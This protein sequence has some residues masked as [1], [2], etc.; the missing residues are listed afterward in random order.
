MK[1]TQANTGALIAAFLLLS[2]VLAG[3]ANTSSIQPASSGVS[4]FKGAAYRGES[5]TIS[6]S[7]PGT[8]EFRVFH[9]GATGFVSVQN[10]R[11]DAEQRAT[12]FC[13]R[14][15]KAMKSLRETTSQ[16][17]H[18]LGNFPRIEIIFSCIEKAASVAARTGDD[19]KYTRL[20]N[21][22][23]LLDTGVLS[24]QEFEREKAKI[25][26]QP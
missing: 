19:P 13:E 16:P 15:E 2:G 23:K 18:I 17:P 14:K 5:V 21:L 22:K 12:Q 26:S 25:L 7:T 3:C 24:E 6:N 4:Q 11:E 9:Q 8:E 1:L 10:V 20:V